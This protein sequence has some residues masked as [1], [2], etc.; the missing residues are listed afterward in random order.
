MPYTGEQK[1]AYDRAWRAAR[2]TAWIKEHGPC[3]WCD[4]WDDL[5]VDHEDPAT[6]LYQPAAL[7]SMALD[8]PKRVAEL[9]KCQVLC[10]DCHRVK[11]RDDLPDVPHGNTGY[12]NGCR[13]DECKADHAR[14]NALY[15]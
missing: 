12:G 6:K 15:R 5:E 8:N 4:S 14:V 13:C 10:H 3:K 2:R 9:A 11:S 7:W 1:R